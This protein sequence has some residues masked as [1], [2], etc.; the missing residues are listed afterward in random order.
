MP[1]DKN[2]H[3]VSSVCTATSVV[4]DDIKEL[5][6]YVF[7]HK[8]THRIHSHL[9]THVHTHVRMHMHTHNM[10][11]Y[12]LSNAIFIEFTEEVAVSSSPLITSTWC[13]VSH[14]TMY[15]RFV[16]SK[17]LPLQLSN[18]IDISIPTKNR[19]Q[20]RTLHHKIYRNSLPIYTSIWMVHTAEGKLQWHWSY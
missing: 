16:M 3:I 5:T 12:S 7:T 17:D 18:I 13:H 4:W 19:N 11:G 2:C 9:P 6:I 14:I 10:T 8:H 1:N 20:C 15:L